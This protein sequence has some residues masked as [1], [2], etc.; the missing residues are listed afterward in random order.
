MRHPL[1]ILFTAI[2]IGAGAQDVPTFKV[3]TESAFVW[4]QDRVNG[5]VSSEIVDPLTGNSIHKLKHQGIEVGTQI[6]KDSLASWGER[7]GFIVTEVYLVNNTDHE[8]AIEYGGS[9]YDGNPA[10]LVSLVRSLKETPKAERKDLY[11]VSKFSC[12][13]SGEFPTAPLFGEHVPKSNRIVSKTVQPHLGTA[14]SSIVFGPNHTACS[15]ETGVKQCHNI[16]DFASGK[17]RQYF[18]VGGKDYVFVWDGAGIK[19]CGAR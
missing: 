6:A 9:S 12:F 17:F 3:E 7:F 2:A 5:A 19:T 4:G 16:Y 14:I 10:P 15:S 18:R 8:V 1:A 13:R 11:E